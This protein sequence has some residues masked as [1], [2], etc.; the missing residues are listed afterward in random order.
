MGIRLMIIELGKY[1]SAKELHID[2]RT[3]GSQGHICYQN[4]DWRVSVTRVA[5][6]M[7]VEETGMRT[8]YRGTY[9]QAPSQE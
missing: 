2:T 7:G 1:N 6:H 4:G 9:K 3:T 8:G 5:V